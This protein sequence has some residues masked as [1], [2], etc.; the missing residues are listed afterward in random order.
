M[1]TSNAGTTNDQSSKPKSVSR[2]LVV[3]AF[4]IIY[5]VWGSTYLAIRVTVETLPPFLSAAARFSVAGAALLLFLRLRGVPLPDRAQW[6]RSCIAGALMLVG[7]NGLVVWAEQ[8]ISSG[9]AALLVALTPIWFALLDWARPGGA[10]P[11]SKTIVG[12]IIGFS[13]IVVLVNG[14]ARNGGFLGSLAVI[15]AGICWA[16]GSLYSKHTSGAT[17]PWM[18]AATQML[19]GAAGLLFVGLIL[20]EP[21]RTDWSA[22][23][24]RSLLALGYL[25]VFG[26]WIAYSAYVFLLEVSTPS[27]V[28]TYAYVNPVTAVFLGWAL[29]GESVTA[30]MLAGMLVVLAGVVI[31]TVP[32]LGRGR[33]LLKADQKLVAGRTRY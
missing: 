23:S 2:A 29:L 19:C 24:G 26:S 12:I 16:G 3:A 11:T 9:L 13:G 15:V 1:S 33:G 10:R 22:I 18:N 17:S 32:H 8:S 27:R 5:V 7:G 25:I 14:G 30:R 6:Q 4:A 21:F 20:R 31:I 28:S